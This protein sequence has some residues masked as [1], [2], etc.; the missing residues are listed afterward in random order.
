MSRAEIHD[1]TRLLITDPGRILHNNI[2]TIVVS[3]NPFSRLFSAYID[4][5][6]M[7][8]FWDQ[9]SFMDN[10][11]VLPSYVINGT[12]DVLKSS[13]T[14]LSSRLVKYKDSLRQKGLLIKKNIT[15]KITPV[16][17]NNAT[18]GDFL[19]FIISEVKSGR[20]LEPHWAPISHLCH[21]CRFNTVK[22]VKQESFAQDVD[23]TLASVGVDLTS[24]TWLNRSLN[25][26]RAE[27]SV[28][29][30]VAVVEHKLKQRAVKNCIDKSEVLQRLWKSFQIQGFINRN[31]EYPEEQL[32]VQ[33]F[34]QQNVSN[35]ILGAISQKPMTSSANRNQREFF[36]KQAYGAIPLDV[37]A[38]IQDIYYLD[39]LLFNYSVSPPK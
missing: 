18:F 6:Y 26:N 1:R 22:I 10:V 5:V 36:L 13:N 34:N 32:H 38:A 15:Q 7:P 27:N 25:E 19:K 21:P 9:F 31:I 39:F 20:A 23:H 11:R 30:I 29:G 8:L 37:I 3:R 16:C 24:Y 2:P 14:P 35:Y 17:A 28:P 4:K 12:I 33:T